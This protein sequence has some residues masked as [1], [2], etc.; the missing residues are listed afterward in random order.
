[1]YICE[2]LIGLL[3]KFGFFWPNVT[4]NQN[5]I[6][7]SEIV[8]KSLGVLLTQTCT[9]LRLYSIYAPWNVLIKSISTHSV[10]G[11]GGT[12]CS[13]NTRTHLRISDDLWCTHEH[14]PKIAPL[15][16]L[17]F[18]MIIGSNLI[19][20]GIQGWLSL[21][22]DPNGFKTRTFVHTASKTVCYSGFQLTR[23]DWW[24]KS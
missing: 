20:G 7:P 18:P 9:C 5:Q 15:A 24:L 14:E 8:W 6:S 23:G 3:L 4:V 17:F 22:K 19:Q 10:Q 12:V 16:L 13:F 2:Q 1:M 21:P 11:G